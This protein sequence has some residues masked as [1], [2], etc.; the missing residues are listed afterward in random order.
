MLQ[1]SNGTDISIDMSRR[2]QGLGFARIA[3]LVTSKNVNILKKEEIQSNGSGMA[4]KTESKQDLLV[5]TKVET[6]EA[7]RR[8]QKLNLSEAIKTVKTV[9]VPKVVKSEAKEDSEHP[10]SIESNLDVDTAN[11]RLDPVPESQSQVSF[12]RRP[13]TS[14]TSLE[15]PVDI[16]DLT[17]SRTSPPKTCLSAQSIVYKF[18]YRAT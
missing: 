6:G 13:E 5:E 15:D 17:L 18:Q 4:P 8:W 3:K 12:I 9:K 7:G 14:S 1:P 10:H 11:S 2:N 16:C